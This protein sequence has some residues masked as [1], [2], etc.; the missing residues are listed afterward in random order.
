M[1]HCG[2]GRS[3]WVRS[4]LALREGG[5]IV[6]RYRSS[7]PLTKA[8]EADLTAHRTP[9][10][11]GPATVDGPAYVERGQPLGDETDDTED[12]DYPALPAWDEL[13]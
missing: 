4:R 9:W 2:L 10:I 12:L 11:G 5:S 3:D 1:F 6:I 8:L 13:L 7:P